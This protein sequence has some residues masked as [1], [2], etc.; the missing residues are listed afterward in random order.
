MRKLLT[1]Q[2]FSVHMKKKKY[3][4]LTGSV[5]NIPTMYF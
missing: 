5:M 1:I 3:R 2:T 4:L